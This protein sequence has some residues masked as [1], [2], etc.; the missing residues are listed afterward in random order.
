MVFPRTCSNFS[1]SQSS[2]S[3]Y[4]SLVSNTSQWDD[5]RLCGGIESVDGQNAPQV[6]SPLEQMEQ[7]PYGWERIDDPQ[8]GTYYIE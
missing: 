8:Y 4:S 2:Y 1:Y 7:L 5:P 3:F 6:G